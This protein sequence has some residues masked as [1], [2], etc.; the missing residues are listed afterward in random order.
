MNLMYFQSGGPT[1]V[2]NS[3]F[4]GVIEAFQNSNKI[5]KLY[6]SKFGLSGLINNDY[7]EIKKNKNYKSIIKNSG[8]ILGSARIKLSE[9]FNDKIYD[10]ILKNTLNL[11]LVLIPKTFKTLENSS[12]QS[13]HINN[14]VQPQISIMKS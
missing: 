9:D 7:F 10:A 13:S 6:A 4:F 3:S 11:D 2:I 12:K 5:D 1:S 14:N 8:A